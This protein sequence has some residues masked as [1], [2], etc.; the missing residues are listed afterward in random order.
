MTYA[1]VHVLGG[2]LVCVCV[3][4]SHA[5][6]G[7]VSMTVL[8]PFA[9]YCALSSLSLTLFPTF[10]L[11]YSMRPEDRPS[12]KEICKFVENSVKK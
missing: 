10:S 8:F 12:F 11:S 5:L 7:C 9:A 4:E 3:S 6:C 2:V 1:P